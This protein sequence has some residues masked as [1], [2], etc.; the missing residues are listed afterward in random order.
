MQRIKQSK[1]WAEMERKDASG[2]PVPFSLAFVK[3]S[4]GEI[5]Q[6]PKCTCT[7]IH[8]KGSTLNIMLDGETRPKTIRKCLIIAFNGASVYL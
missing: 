4:T 3:K 5:V 2:T 1:L 6:V 7:S 8:S